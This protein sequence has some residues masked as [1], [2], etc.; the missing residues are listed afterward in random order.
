MLD[1][2]IQQGIGNGLAIMNDRWHRE[3]PTDPYSR[4]IPGY[5]PAIRTAGFE[6]NRSENSWSLHKANYLRLKSLEVGYSLPNRLLNTYGID[7][8][9]F[10]INCNNLRTLT[11]NNE[12]MKNVDPESNS[13]LLRY[14]PQTKTYNFGINVT[15]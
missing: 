7:R 13:N 8:I 10:Y 4:W 2:F 12:F 9:R 1:P 6:A 11:S 3:D 14:Y 5:M 15:F